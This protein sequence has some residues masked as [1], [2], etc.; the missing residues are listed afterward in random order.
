LTRHR[1]GRRRNRRGLRF[2]EIRFDQRRKRGQ[3][4]GGVGPAGNQR[5]RVAL[6]QRQRHQGDRAADIGLATVRLDLK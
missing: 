6:G 1:R 4:G 5:H 2:V 3:G